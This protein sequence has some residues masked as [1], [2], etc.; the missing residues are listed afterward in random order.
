M[1]LTNELSARFSHRQPLGAA[2][3]ATGASSP[4]VG[5]PPGGRWPLRNATGGATG[6]AGGQPA[7]EPDVPGL[8]GEP[9]GDENRGGNRGGGDAGG[10]SRG[11]APGSGATERGGVG[12]GAGVGSPPG[13][14]SK[15]GGV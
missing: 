13:E 10:G 12:E 15:S 7:K 9:S 1:I 4:D 11:G 8:G 5:A 2:L 14:T 3:W 6:G